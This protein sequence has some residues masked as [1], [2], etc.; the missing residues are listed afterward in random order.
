LL[1]EASR[2][3]VQSNI[4]AV[5]LINLERTAESSGLANEIS[6]NGLIFMTVDYCDQY[7]SVVFVSGRYQ[8]LEQRY[9]FLPHQFS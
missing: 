8:V 9:E 5:S 4:R 6:G 2:A 7:F 3:K 1:S